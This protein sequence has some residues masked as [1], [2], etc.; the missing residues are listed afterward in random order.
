MTASSIRPRRRPN[1]A[2]TLVELLVVI[3][4]IALLISILLPALNK[5]RGAAKSISCGANLRSIGQAM[6]V[7]AAQWK[8][9]LLGGPTTTA[10]FLFNSGYTNLNSTYNDSNMPEVITIFDWISPTA[11]T[12]GMKFKD[13]GTPLERYGDLDSRMVTLLMNKAFQCPDND[14]IATQGSFG[15]SSTPAYPPAGIPSVSYV[16]ALYFHLL[17]ASNDTSIG[18]AYRAAAGSSPRVRAYPFCNVPDGYTPNLSRIKNSARKIFVADGSR[19][20]RPDQ[21]P[22]ITPNYNSGGGGI[23]GDHGAFSNQSN[24]FASAESGVSLLFGS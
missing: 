15:L 12:M 1:R 7:Y 9:S 17:P 10:R 18:G 14:V 22:N 6:Q 11:K 24:A 16:S 13:G 20:S 23:F 4:I 2:F 19:Y 8:G 3:G 5:A 21:S